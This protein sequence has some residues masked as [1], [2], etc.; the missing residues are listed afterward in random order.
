MW[1][2]FFGH[3][4]PP[5]GRLGCIFPALAEPPHKWAGQESPGLGLVGRGKQGGWA[6]SPCHPF[7]CTRR[8]PKPCSPIPQH[9]RALSFLTH[10][11]DIGVGRFLLFFWP[12][13]T[14]QSLERLLWLGTWG[15]GWT[16]ADSLHPSHPRTA[17]SEPLLHPPPGCVLQEASRF[18]SGSHD[19]GLEQATVS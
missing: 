10:S 4:P 11:L 17:L 5:S 15:S 2:S 6:T 7:F 3:S 9:N 12:P 14:S 1:N 19:P 16:V 13:N 8:M 18:P